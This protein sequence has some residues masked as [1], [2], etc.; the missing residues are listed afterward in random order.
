[1]VLL[2]YEETILKIPCRCQKTQGSKQLTAIA[3]DISRLVGC[4][5]VTK[6]P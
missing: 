4:G 1:M 5:N 6:T 2:N 3:T